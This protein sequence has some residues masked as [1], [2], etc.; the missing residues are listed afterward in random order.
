M[1]TLIL[2]TALVYVSMLTMSMVIGAA[3]MP[4]PPKGLV[5]L[6]AAAC[7]WSAAVAGFVVG[8]WL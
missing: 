7:M 6:C 4:H 8:R 2:V 3:A 5:L 1:M